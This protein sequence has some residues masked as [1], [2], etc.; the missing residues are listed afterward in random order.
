M[1]SLNPCQR[2]EHGDSYIFDLQRGGTS[3][4]RSKHQMNWSES[5]FLRD[6]YLVRWEEADGGGFEPLAA[7]VVV[8]EGGNVGCGR[9]ALER[10]SIGGEILAGGGDLLEG[11]APDSPQWR[12]RE[13]A[14]LG[15]NRVRIVQLEASRVLQGRGS[16]RG[17]RKGERLRI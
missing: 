13:R 10:A 4:K 11:E 2:N 5:E 15:G 9:E 8:S 6:V 17:R 7:E 12:P 1:N 16:V 3:S 14:R